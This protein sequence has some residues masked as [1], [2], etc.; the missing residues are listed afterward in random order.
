MGLPWEALMDGRYGREQKVTVEMKEWLYERKRQD[1]RLS[2]PEL[3]H[4][5]EKRFEVKLSVGHV[6]SLLREVGLSGQPGRPA[7]A[8]TDREEASAAVEEQVVDNAGLFFLEAAKQEMGVVEAVRESVETRRQEYQT[9]HETASLR[10]LK[11]A[12][13]TIWSKLD[14]LLYLPL[15]N[16]T[17]PRDLYYYQGDGLQSLYGFTYKYLPLEQFLGQLSHLCWGQPLA[18]VLAHCYAQAWYPGDEALFI[19]T[20][21]HVKPHWTKAA[22]HSGAVTMWG[23]VMPGTKQLL[24][25]GPQGRWLIGW[26]RAIDGHFKG[27]L[28]EMEE[29]LATILARPIAYNI[30]DS[31]GS[32]LPLA[33]RYAEADRYYLSVLPRNPRQALTAFKVSQEW[34]AVSADPEHEVVEAAWADEHKAAQE[35]RQLILMRPVNQTDPTRVYAG[36]IPSDLSLTQVP[37]T[38]RQRWQHQERRIREIVNGANLNANYGYR[39]D[40]VPHRTRQREWQEAQEKA[41]VTQ[42]KLVR[43]T[44]ALLNLRP[45]L[46]QLRASY[47]R[48][49][50]SLLAELDHRQQELAQRQQQGRPTQRVQQGLAA[51]ERK[52]KQLRA[53]YQKRRASLLRRLRKHRHQRRHLQAQLSVREAE[54]DAIDTDTL[55]RERHLEK[56]QIMLNLQLLLTN[57]HHWAQVHYFSPEWQK[58]EL[59]TATRLIYQKPGRVKWTEDQIEVELEPYR[60]PDQQRAMEAT[61]DRFNAANLRWRDGRLLRI[62]VAKGP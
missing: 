38:F 59:E 52:L 60:Y 2:G 47:T 51:R 25:S 37:P 1:E 36:R 17:R 40:K 35:V 16:L 9:S 57:L 13:E 19:F 18:E 24:V 21:W 15:L 20:D 14:H 48:Q 5:L 54:R 46:V 26:N 28:V 8:K 3:T 7:G 58:L 11:S 53:S 10:V 33:Q 56:D 55:C 32:G 30:V 50:H 43:H 6:N 34:Q 31:E 61:C 29:E 44:E 22:T 41:A 23:R 45:Q 39:Y 62:Y 12:M 42:G 49:R 27:V 4:Q